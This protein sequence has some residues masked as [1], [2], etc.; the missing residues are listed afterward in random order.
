VSTFGLDFFISDKGVFL[1][2]L[3]VDGKGC[4][5]SSGS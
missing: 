4:L 1:G 2:C 5:I 3:L